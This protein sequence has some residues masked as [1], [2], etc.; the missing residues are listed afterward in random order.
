[1][2]AQN[3]RYEA[4][5]AK[6][7]AEDKRYD[8][9]LDKWEEQSQRVDALLDGWDRI[10]GVLEERSGDRQGVKAVSSKPQASD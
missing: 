10:L 2:D 8:A 3:K 4:L 5:L 9:M 7:E 6:W 1:M